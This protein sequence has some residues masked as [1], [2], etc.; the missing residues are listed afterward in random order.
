MEGKTKWDADCLKQPDEMNNLLTLT[1]PLQRDNQAI[2]TKIISSL[3]SELKEARMKINELET[4]QRHSKKVI[5]KFLQKVDEERTAWRSR[6]RE[7]IHAVIDDAKANLMRERKNHQRLEMIN[8]KLIDQLADAKLLANCYM[9]EY[10]K[11]RKAREMVEEVCGELVKEIGD[12]RMEMK[13]LK[14]K[15]RE[16]LEEVEE[17]RRMLQMAEVWREERVQMKLI[18]AK[19]MLE[20][21]YSQ[22]NKLLEDLESFMK[23]HQVTLNMEEI[24]KMESLKQMTDSVNIEDVR[25]LAHE[26]SNPDDIFCVF[27][28]VNF[29]GSGERELVSS[30][31]NEKLL[32]ED[33]TNQCPGMDKKCELEEDASE[34]ETV[35]RRDDEDSSYSSSDPSVSKTFQVSSSSL[36]GT[37]GEKEVAEDVPSVS[38]LSRSC[39]NNVEN[40]KIHTPNDKNEKLLNSHVPQDMDG[41]SS[42]SSPNSGNPHLPWALKGCI[43]WPCSAQKSSSKTKMMEVG[44]VD[45]EKIQLRHVLKQKI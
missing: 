45:S 44:M 30:C 42:N 35:S 16:L 13:V 25:E 36:T 10:E 34:W 43:E 31:G 6:A 12:S 29:G 14:R 7:K 20:E 37:E 24:K 11:E 28:D 5:K 38:K 4:E 23:S 21:K 26:P 1:K 9:Q 33:G 32:N 18:D 22:M 39:P 27:D 19:V 8:A 17:E 41:Q 3:N 40:Y 2:A 15:S